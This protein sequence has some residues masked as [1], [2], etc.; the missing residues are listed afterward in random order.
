MPPSLKRILS[1]A[2]LGLIIVAVACVA[3]LLLSLFGMHVS[4]YPPS[5]T[6]LQY[7]PPQ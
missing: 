6:H 5:Q 4:A 2:L 7:V 3:Y 1:Y